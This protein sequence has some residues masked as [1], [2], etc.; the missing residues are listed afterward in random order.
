MKKFLL[1]SI[2]LASATFVS[3]DEV[4]TKESDG[5]YVVNTTTLCNVIGYRATTPLKV[6]IKSSKVVKVE[7]LPCRE[8]PKYYKLV[9]DQMIPKFAGKKAN[10][11]KKVDGVTG[12]TM[13]SNAV[14]ENVKAALNYYKKHAK[15]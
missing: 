1:M 9:K 15:K 4:M 6:Y 14:R 8:T 10:N 2:M 5:T 12:A 11:L 3:A 13:S 7:P